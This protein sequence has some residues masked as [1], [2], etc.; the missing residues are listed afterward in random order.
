MNVEDLVILMIASFRDIYRQIDR[1]L[2]FMNK[3]LAKVG[4]RFGEATQGLMRRANRLTC[5]MKGLN[6]RIYGVNRCIDTLAVEL[7]ARTDEANRRMD[8]VNKNI[9]ETS[10]RIDA[11]GAVLSW[12]I[13]EASGR[14]DG[15]YQVLGDLQAAVMGVVEVVLENQKTVSEMAKALFSLQR[16]LEEVRKV[17]LR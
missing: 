4:D 16:D 15:V 2:E 17:L 12:C 7:G 11:M 8:E 6:A 14:I 3:R 13:G 10:K 1:V 9:D 5:S